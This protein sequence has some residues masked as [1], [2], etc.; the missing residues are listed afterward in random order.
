L[1]IAG[2]GE[3]GHQQGKQI[4]N[5]KF[6]FFIDHLKKTNIGENR[7]SYNFAYIDILKRENDKAD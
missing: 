3:G 5:C 7:P 2:N 6:L 1:S 4:Q